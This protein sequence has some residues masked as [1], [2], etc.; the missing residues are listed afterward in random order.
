MSDKTELT[1]NAAEAERYRLMYEQSTDMLSRHTATP[2]W[3]FIDASP[4]CEKILGYTVDELIGLSS[5]DQMHPEDANNLKK[6]AK[7]VKYSN[8][9][10][11]NL[12]RYRHKDGHYLWLETTSRTIR[13][14]DGKALEVI[15]VSRDVTGR[16]LAEQ[17]TRRLA[18]VVEASSDMILFC[19]HQNKQITYMNESCYRTLGLSKQSNTTRFLQQFFIKGQYEDVV[20]PAL[21]DAAVFGN[22]LGSIPMRLPTSLKK[23]R[24]A[25]VREIICHHNSNESNQPLVEYYTVIARDIT[26]QKKAQEAAKKQLQEITHMSRFLSVG[27]M[28]T[29]LAHELN[30]PLGAIMNYCR[31]SKRRL[32]E[33]DTSDDLSAIKE[34]MDLIAKQAKRA[35]EI[36]KRMRNFVRKTDS[37]YSSFSINKAC[38]DVCGFLTQEARDNAISFEFSFKKGLPNIYADRIQIEQVLLNIIRNAIEAYT[39]TQKTL[40]PIA[41]TT[42]RENGSIEITVTDAAKGIPEVQLNSI[43]EPFQTSKSN[44]LGMGLPISRSI[45]EN[46]GGQ[47]WAQSDGITGT[48]FKIRLPLQEQA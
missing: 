6:R 22:W 44:G 33:L 16:E 12:H 29:G 5:Y 47:L 18:R 39:N 11:T 1:G 10:Y 15:C 17:S 48:E 4:A 23:R 25:E 35:S 45:I 37:K 14:N 27:E 30:Q 36:I 19:D 31:G 26:A 40:R 8:G 2:E 42:T 43:F 9:V 28:A 24:Y 3:T 34:A 7:S 41:I 20:R 38:Q 32:Q 21:Q 13:D 46:H